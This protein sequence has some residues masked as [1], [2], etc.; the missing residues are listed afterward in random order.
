MYIRYRNVAVC[1]LLSIITCGIYNLYWF[2]RMTDEVNAVSGE[3]DTSGGAALLL[4]LVT[5]GIYY[6]VWNYKIGDKLDRTRAYNGLAT[7]S[8]GLV[9]L[10]LSLFG[11]GIVSQALAQ[12]EINKYANVA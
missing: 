10:L 5:C 8:Y 2:V 9:F 11:L 12:N 3:P 1:I 6:F 4:T 7:D